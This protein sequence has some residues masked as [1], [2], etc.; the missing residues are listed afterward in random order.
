MPGSPAGGR[1]DVTPTELR[2]IKFIFKWVFRVV[3]LAV[4]LV[5]IFFLSLNSIARVLMEHRIRAQTGMDAEI[6]SVSIGL[7]EPRMEIRDLKLFNPPSYGGT[8]F[9]D[10]PEFHVEYDRVALAESK[11]HVTLLRL[12]L[13]E[14]DIVKNEAG[15]TNIF[16]LG[17]AL[18]L[19]G[20]KKGGIAVARPP[21]LPDFRKQTGLSFETIDALN[22]SVGTLKFIDLK[23]QS[24]NRTQKIGIDNFVIK[25]VKSPADLLGLTVLIALRSGDFFNALVDPQTADSPAGLLKLLF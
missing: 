11:L 4:V 10:I 21:Q 15:Q 8:P 12:N 1:A 23:D 7:L 6:G 9:I 18:P 16:A 13:G 25:N 14:V 19:P 22:I 17:L 2:L 20:P 3:L 5:V 24:R